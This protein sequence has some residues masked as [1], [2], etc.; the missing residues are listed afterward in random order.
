MARPRMSDAMHALRDS[1]YKFRGKT[2]SKMTA[3]RPKMPSHLGTVARREWKRIMPFLLNRGSLTEADATA[4]SLHVEVHARWLASKQDLEKRG[5]MVDV[6]VLDSN[7]QPVITRKVNPSLRIAQDCERA[8]RVSLRELGLT[9]ATRER[10]LPAKPDEKEQETL[11]GKI[12][13]GMD[14]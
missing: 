12:L 2:M 3:G 8:L 9:P 13:K 7:G 4:L 11:I 14:K 6:T 5:L 1:T 10:V